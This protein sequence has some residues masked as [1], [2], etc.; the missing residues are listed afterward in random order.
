[1]SAAEQIKEHRCLAYT[2]KLYQNNNL[3]TEPKTT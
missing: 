2:L 1:M 3:T